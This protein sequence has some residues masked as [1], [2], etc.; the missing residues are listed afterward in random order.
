MLRAC[1][2]RLAICVSGG[3]LLIDMEHVCVH[4]GLNLGLALSGIKKA[5]L[6]S[7]Q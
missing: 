6:G 1:R 5:I 3:A 4:W 7:S 2:D